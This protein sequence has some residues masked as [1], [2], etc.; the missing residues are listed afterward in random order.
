[1]KMNISFYTKDNFDNITE[2]IHGLDIFTKNY[3]MNVDETLKQDDLI[4]R[5]DKCPFKSNNENCLI[6]SFAYQ[7]ENDHNNNYDMT[8]F[9]AMGQ[10]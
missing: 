1:M 5:C 7:H 2:A 10:L 8:N 3:C 6:K 4:F 9:G